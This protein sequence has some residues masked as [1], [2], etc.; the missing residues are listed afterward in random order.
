ML[1]RFLN[2]RLSR[3]H[4][5]CVHNRKCCS[6]SV[7]FRY[8]AKKTTMQQGNISKLFTCD[9]EWSCRCNDFALNGDENTL[10]EEFTRIITDPSQCGMKFPHLA[11]LLWVLNDG[12]IPYSGY[13]GYSGTP[14]SS[15]ARRLLKDMQATDHGEDCWL[16][17][18]LRH[19]WSG[20]AR[21]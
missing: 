8:C 3:R 14:D 9:D 12:P 1:K 13:S 19:L 21:P 7:A 18:W 2:E 6:R 15:T 5:N 17:R 16:V 10:K 11:A 4:Q 20:P